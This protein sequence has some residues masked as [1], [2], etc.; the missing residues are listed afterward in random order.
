MSS[1]QF[2]HQTK[3]PDPTLNGNTATS[4]HD[5]QVGILDEKVLTTYSWIIIPTGTL[6]I[7]TKILLW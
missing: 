4:F 5:R 2:H 7:L 6:T 1:Y 3:P